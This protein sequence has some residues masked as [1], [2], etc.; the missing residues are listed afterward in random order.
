MGVLVTTT[1]PAGYP[2]T[3]ADARLQCRLGS[4]TSYDALLLRLIAAATADFEGRIGAH[5]VQRTVRLE[6]DAF[7][8]DE[9]DLL[10]YPVTAITSIKYDDS[11]NTEQTLVANT[12]YY[13]SLSGSC[14]TVWPVTA[15]PATYPNKPAAVRIVMT[16][17]YAHGSASPIVYGTNIPEDIKQAILVAVYDMWNNPGD[18]VVGPSLSSMKVVQSV[19]D[20]YRRYR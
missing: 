10:T 1:A 11:A 3:T 13:T 7:P 12:D 2:V 20:K 6:M 4:D 5:L 14:P 15:W 8:D 9:I 18:Q 16:T 17:G 19:A